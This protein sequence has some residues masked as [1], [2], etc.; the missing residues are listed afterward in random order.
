M[1]VPQ[2]FA[3]RL[4]GA[5]A[6]CMHFPLF[7]LRKYKES[8][9]QAVVAAAKDSRVEAGAA[10]PKKLFAKYSIN[11]ARVLKIKP[12]G[13]YFR[14]TFRLPG[15]ARCE[16]KH[17]HVNWGQGKVKYAKHFLEICINISL[18]AKLDLLNSCV[19]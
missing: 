11:A 4:P 9:G 7:C 3:L 10:W 15:P 13:K 8:I 19:F 1:N 12:Q 18:G 17:K 6:T 2:I 16:E 5:C 14:E